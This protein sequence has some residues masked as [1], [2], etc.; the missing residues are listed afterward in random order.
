MPR[1]LKNVV[2]TLSVSY[3]LIAAAGAFA[4]VIAYLQVPKMIAD[5]LLGISDN[6]YIIILLILLMMMFLGCIMEMAPLI[7]ICT[8]ILLPV[9]T[10][11]GM[12]PIQ[13]G[14]VLIF[15]LAV[16]LCTPP[17]GSALFVGCAVG[18]TS[19][20]KA[21][22]EMIPMYLVMVV[23]LFLVAYIPFFSTWLPGIMM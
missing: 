2:K 19:I 17:V 13:F 9:A 23:V 16:G 6:K 8:P 14:V 5:A 4:W 20:E 7:F 11:I 21:V 12:S 15:V 22:K 1:I 18:K 10:S 3:S